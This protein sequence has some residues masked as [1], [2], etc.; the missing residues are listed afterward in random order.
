MEAFRKYISVYRRARKSPTPANFI[1]L[2]YSKDIKKAWS[3]LNYYFFQE[4]KSF[5]S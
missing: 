4:K 2:E 5:S 3:L 1:N